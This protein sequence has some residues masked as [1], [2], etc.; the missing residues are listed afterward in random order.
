MKRIYRLTGF[1]ENDIFTVTEYLLVSN[2]DL[3]NME[4]AIAF[5]ELM[6][7]GYYTSASNNYVGYIDIDFHRFNKEAVIHILSQLKYIIRQEKLDKL[8]QE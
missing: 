5:E 7:N 2:T 1:Y 8:L 4:G 6:R 3:Y